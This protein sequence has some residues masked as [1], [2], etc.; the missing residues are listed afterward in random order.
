[1]QAAAYVN[2]ARGET[3]V[4]SSPARPEAARFPTLC[5]AASNPNAEPRTSAEANVATAACS[6]VST[7]P[8]AAP[9]VTKQTPRTTML[10]SSPRARHTRTRTPRCRAR[11]PATARCDRRGVP[12]E[13]SRASPTR[14]TRCRGRARSRPRGRDRDPAP[15]ARSHAGSAASQP[16]CRARRR[17]SRRTPTPAAPR[18]RRGPAAGSACARAQ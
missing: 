3:A 10:S 8:I 15:A 14:C 4:Q 1:M 17:R 2:A 13:C 18:R 9:A 16:C 7:Q 12:R 6:A 11:I 5:S